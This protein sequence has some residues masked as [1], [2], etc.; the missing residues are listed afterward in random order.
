M[1]DPKSGG[2]RLGLDQRHLEGQKGKADQQGPFFAALAL[3]K[4]DVGKAQGRGER[5]EGCACEAEG[6]S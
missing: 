3:C 1:P 6:K 2:R 4:G 5:R